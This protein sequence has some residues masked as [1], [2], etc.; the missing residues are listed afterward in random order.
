MSTLE[1]LKKTIPTMSDD[2]IDD[3]ISVI[4]KSRRG[5]RT[6]AR[7]IKSKVSTKKVLTPDSIPDED[8]NDVLKILGEI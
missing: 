1:E 4:R 5:N 7:T 6:A 8:V 2:A 3:L